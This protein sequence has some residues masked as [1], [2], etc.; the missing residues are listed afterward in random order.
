MSR[1]WIAAGLLSLGLAVSPS[2]RAAPDTL[3]GSGS[4]SYTFGTG[5]N[6]WQVDITACHETSSPDCSNEQVIGTVTANGSLVLT[7]EAVSGPSLLSTTAITGPNM[8]MGFNETVTQKSGKLVNSVTLQLTGTIANSG[9][10]LDVHTSMTDTGVGQ[11]FSINTNMTNGSSP[12]TVSQAL[13]TPSSVLTITKDMAASSLHGTS[14]DA[15]ALNTVT[16]TF[17]VPEPASLSLLALGL[18]GLIA[19][20]RHRTRATG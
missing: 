20:R 18:G 11:N 13:A 2:V 14:G 17:N 19:A 12:F 6:Q 4:V 3:P 16:Q 7:Y 8:D 10:A 15:V 9:D 1:F 5:T